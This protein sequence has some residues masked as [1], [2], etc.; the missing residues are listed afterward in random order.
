MK[1]YTLRSLVHIRLNKS[2]LKAYNNIYVKHTKIESSVCMK[3]VCKFKHTSEELRLIESK[4][5]K[6]AYKVISNQYLGVIA[7]GHKV[8]LLQPYIKWGK[9]KKRN[10]RPELQMAESVA[11]VETLLYWN[12]IDKA[13]APLLSFKKKNLLGSGGLDNL[14]KTIQQNKQITAVFVS[15]NLL[16]HV[17][18]MELQ[19]ILGLPVYDRYSIIIHI[20]RQHAKTPEALL[21]VALA[22]LPYIWKKMGEVYEQ[23]SGQINFEE[24][25]KKM[26][27][28]RES[29]LK[30][31]LDKLKEI[32]KGSRNRRKNYGFPSIA[33]VGYTNAGKS[34]LIKILSEDESLKPRNQLF[35]TLDTISYQGLLPSRQKVLYIDT[36]GFIQDVPEML[37]APF[38]VT[39]E[40]ALVSD[41][42][43]HIYDVSHPDAK[44][45][46]QY[47]E[48]IIRP[49]L[50]ERQ[51]VIRVANKCDLI[52]KFDIHED[53]I[54]ISC[55]ESTGINEL[56]LKLEEE[57]VKATGKSLKRIRVESGSLASIWLHKWTTVIN[58][59]PDANN[60]QY[61]ILDVLATD[62]M[63]NDFKQ[64]LKQ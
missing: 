51:P 47:V 6:E 1:M 54:A 63:I 16:K 37:L 60:P 59:E 17:Q 30:R 39:L 43:I 34:S 36:I 48:E 3:I 14:V 61:V 5:E 24:S 42:I 29:K 62:L 64:F 2:L 19:N 25:R 22:E 33:V 7:G 44:A 11:L 53:M 35:A 10:T 26:L 32:R 31:A 49:M 41:V 12:V 38:M 57:V 9:D 56:K 45:Q 20:F 50:N 58:S 4:E 46:F 52:E 23:H 8:F 27:K 21:Q 13:F 40:D 55:K 15:I 28:A 18:R